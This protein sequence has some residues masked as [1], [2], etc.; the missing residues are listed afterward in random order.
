M[1]NFFNPKVVAVI[2][3]SRNPNKVG[4]IIFRNFLEGKF[5]GKVFAVNPNAQSIFDHKVYSS[6]LSVPE[7]ID[8]AVITI[9]SA[10]VSQA[11]KQCGK[12]RIPAVII[13]SA[14]FGEIGNHDMDEEVKTIAK[15]Y[16][17]KVLGP[18]CLGIYDPSSGV[19]TLFL[20]RY[21]LGRPEAGSIS[22]ISQSGATGSV[23]LDWMAMKG[24]RISK[25]VSYGNAT[26]LD[27]ADL[28][29]FL[30]ND[31]STKVICLYIEGVREGKKFFSIAKKLSKKKP[32][33]VLKGG[34][35]AAGG[36]ATLSHTGSLAG[37]ARIYTAAFKQAGIIQAENLEQIF[38]FARVFSTQP[39]PKG[40]KVQII[41]D[42]GGYGV[43]T[44]DAVIKNNLELAEMKPITV[45]SL[46]K[47]MPPYV[48]IKNPIDLTG[49][50]DTKRYQF[51][52]T[53]ALEDPAVDMIALVALFQVPALGGDVVEV[54]TEAKGRKPLVVIAGGGKYTEALK[55]PLEDSGV[56]TFSYPE[57]AIASLRV[58]Y[59]FSKK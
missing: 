20:P 16:S 49:D 59:E 12:K 28:M 9:P 55:K 39:L 22:Y 18:N 10:L 37:E 43:L 48:V 2:G 57:Q 44:A 40:K 14:G 6:V 5:R 4:H 29:Q 52:L 31:P 1:H 23:V 45:Q 17:I 53:A 27:E 15:K 3:A 25:F 46:K 36:K 13:I 54:I 30:V 19:D 8:L 26:V 38:D 24:Y 50:A 35:T 42:G 51:A 11:L 32:I 47:Y 33:I 58:L 41:T 34:Q 7:K 21:K 56:P